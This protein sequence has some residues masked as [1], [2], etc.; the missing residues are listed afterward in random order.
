MTLLSLLILFKIAMTA[1]TTSG[2]MLLLPG[3]RIGGLFGVGVEAAPLARLYGIALTAMLIGYGSGV[4]QAEQDRL[5]VGIV[6]MGLVSNL[7]ASGYLAASG[8][9]RRATALTA[10]YGAIGV[11]LASALLAPSF[12]L[13]RAW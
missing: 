1:V 2:P 6:W 12:W 13:G 8:G 4:V 11:A 10:L 7:G 9:W 5:P 3:H